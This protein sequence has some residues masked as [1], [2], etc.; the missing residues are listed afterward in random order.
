M[1][2]GIEGVSNQIDKGNDDKGSVYHNGMGAWQAIRLQGNLAS[3]SQQLNFGDRLV[4]Q[5]RDF[6]LF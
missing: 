6:G 1:S 2:D 3:V 4:N 5:L